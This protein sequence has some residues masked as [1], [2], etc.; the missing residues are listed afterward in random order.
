MSIFLCYLLE[1]YYILIT[2]LYKLHL[3]QIYLNIYYFLE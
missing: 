3:Y 2:I 1:I